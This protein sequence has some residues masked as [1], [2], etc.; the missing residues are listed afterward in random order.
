[1]MGRAFQEAIFRFNSSFYTM[2]SLT[3]LNKYIRNKLMLTE[4]PIPEKIKFEISTPSE[5]NIY[6]I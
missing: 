3:P 1:M 4:E 2:N 5:I 6:I